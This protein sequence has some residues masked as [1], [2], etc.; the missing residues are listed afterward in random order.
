MI[1]P[2]HGRRAKLQ[3]GR[4]DL[5]LMPSE[6]QRFAL[7]L[8]TSGAMEGA[9]SVVPVTLLQTLRPAAEDLE[10]SAWLVAARD[11]NSLRGNVPKA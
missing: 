9:V 5:E 10:G 2:L 3:R 1:P 11:E 4:K 8:R 6:P 7:E